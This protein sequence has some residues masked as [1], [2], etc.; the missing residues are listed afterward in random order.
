MCLPHKR[1]F[2]FR[3]DLIFIFRYFKQT[4]LVSDNQGIQETTISVKTFTKKKKKL[5]FR[6]LGKFQ[7]VDSH[8]IYAEVR[9]N[10]APRY[11]GHSYMFY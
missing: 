10:A 3:S 5:L 9:H 4:V 6:A 11:I 8:Q 2:R 7:G 1:Y